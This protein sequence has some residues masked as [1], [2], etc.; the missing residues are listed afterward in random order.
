[1]LFATLFT[2]YFTLHTRTGSGPDG[3]EIFELTP[4]LWETFLLLTSSFTIGLGV[5]AM[6]IGRKSDDDILYHHSFTRSWLLSH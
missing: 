4:V 6:R 5:H 1:M 2:V 3:A